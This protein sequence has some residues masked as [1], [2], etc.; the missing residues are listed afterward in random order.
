[1]NSFIKYCL[2]KKVSGYVHDD[3][4][5]TDK[6]ELFNMGES[7][8]SPSKKVER[9]LK[10]F[11]IN[12]L[13]AYLDPSYKKLRQTIAKKHQVRMENVMLSSG[14]DEAINLIPRA[15]S[16]PGDCSVLAVPTFYRMIE[17][18]TMFK[19]NNHLVNMREKNGFSCDDEFIKRFIYEIKLKKAK[20]AWICNPNNP[21][22][23]IIKLNHI[24]DILRNIPRS[25]VLV[26]DE[27]FF[28]FY[29]PINKKSAVNLISKYDNLAVIRSLSKSYSLAGIRMGYLLSTEKIIR[30]VNSIK[31]VFNINALSQCAA[32]AALEDKKYIIDVAEKTKKSRE[33]L[34]LEI[35]KLN[36]YV[37]SGDSCTNV[38]IIKHKSKDLY[39]ELKKKK[40][41]AADFRQSSGMSGLGYVRITI[42]NT[43]KN[44]KLLEALKKIN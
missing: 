30:D 4:K 6:Y 37:I 28:D 44:K 26:V 9:A 21:T 29:D 24:E 18:N 13:S 42:Q 2:N 33:D 38:F 15:L 23:K 16:D 5:N 25:C 7:F 3:I 20:T 27:V 14:A 40:I 39:E 35:S 31:P 32:Q 1:M 19:I 17:A 22:G 12:E 10:T 36:S 41:L 43:K 34:F 8:L 11:K